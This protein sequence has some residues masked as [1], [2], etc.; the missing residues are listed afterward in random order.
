MQH[1]AYNKLYSLSEKVHSLDDADIRQDF[2]YLQVS[3]H[4]YYMSTKFFSDG[5]VHSYFNPYDSPYDAFINYMNVLSDFEIRVNAAVQAGADDD[6]ARLSKIILEKEEQ[7]EKLEK[8]LAA[9]ETSAL[10]KK[11]TPKKASTSRKPSSQQ[12]AGAL[13]KVSAAK[14]GPTPKKSKKS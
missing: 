1:E 3:D 12:N 10:K 8:R 13:K 9:K 4:F 6:V 14:K 11:S 5:E 2:D 7:L